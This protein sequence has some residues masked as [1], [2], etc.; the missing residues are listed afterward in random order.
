MSAKGL[1]LE[2]PKTGEERIAAALIAVSFF[3]HLVLYLGLTPNI[4]RSPMPINEE[5]QVEAQLIADVDVSSTDKD[6]LPDA[7]E[8]KSSKVPETLLP[9]LPKKF[10]IDDKV[11]GETVVEDGLPSKEQKAD[12]IAEK[13][14][15]DQN[16]RKVDEEEKNRLKKEEAMRRLAIERLRREQKNS[17]K[18]ETEKR[19]AIARLKQKA[20]SNKDIN[21]GA[22]SGL[23]LGSDQYLSKLQVHIRRCYSVPTAYNLQNAEL[24]VAIAIVVSERGGLM[25]TTIQGP[26]G[27]QV[28]DELAF[29]AVKDCSPMP[30]PPERLAGT[31]ITLN[32]TP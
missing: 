21:V 28:F 11:K 9:Q 27:D 10:A 23:G 24:K 3:V 32:F 5:W 1:N 18:L 25:S 20:A 31:A 26:S 13:T 17:N 19:D 6:T 16:Q 14:Q 22:E 8:K 15:E 12:K 2:G 30:P 7:E 4:M 29:K